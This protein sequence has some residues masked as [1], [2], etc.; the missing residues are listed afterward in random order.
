MYVPPTVI[1]YRVKMDE[2]IAEAVVYSG[3]WYDRRVG[4]GQRNDRV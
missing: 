4:Q 3:V 1:L 2:G